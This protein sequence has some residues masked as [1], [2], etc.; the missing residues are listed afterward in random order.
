MAQ[1]TKASRAAPQRRFENYVLTRTTSPDIALA[2]IPDSAMTPVIAGNVTDATTSLLNIGFDFSF[3]NITYKR[4]I[5]NNN[6]WLALAGPTE[7]TSGSIV[8]SLLLSESYQNEGINLTNVS[9]NVLVC[10]WFDSLR[11]VTNTVNN[12]T[13]TIGA[14]KANRISQGI[15]TPPATFDQTNYGVR[16]FNDARSRD[17]RRLVV[18]WT[19]V[20]DYAVTQFNNIVKFD[21]VIYENGKIEFRYAPRSDISLTEAS[22]SIS[23]TYVQDATV[24]IF[25]PGTNRFRDFSPGLGHN[26]NRRRQHKYGGAEYDAS[27]ADAGLENVPTSHFVSRPYSWRL[28]TNVHW[29]SSEN[30]GGI[31]TFAPPMNKRRVL[32]R[33]ILRTVDAE[34]RLPTVVRTGGTKRKISSFFD[35]RKTVVYVDAGFNETTQVTTGVLVNFP[36]TLQRFHGGTAPGVVERQNLFVGDYEFTASISK[37]A[38]DDFVNQAQ[39][40]T[41][42][43]WSEHKLFAADQ[44]ATTD[45][46][47]SGSNIEQLGDG[48]SQPLRA[49]TQLRFSLPVNFT[50][51]M[52]GISSSIYYYNAK[53][54]CWEIPQNSV[55]HINELATTMPA[56]SKGD[57][58]RY[59]SVTGGAVESMRGFNAIGG[60][61]VSGSTAPLFGLP[62]TDTMINASYSAENVATALTRNYGKSINVNPNYQATQNE[63]LTLPINHDFLIEKAVIDIPLAFGAGWFNDV[64]TA[65]Q[66]L[67]NPFLEVS[68]AFD[69]GGPALTVSLFNQFKLGN[70][71][72]RELIMT[73]TITHVDDNVARIVVSNFPPITNT[74]Q[75]RQQG[76]KAFNV[77]P[78]AIVTPITT[79]G[80]TMTFTGSVPVKMTAMTSN[81][82]TVNVMRSMNVV[83]TQLNLSGV[84]ELFNTPK[85]QLGTFTTT[86]YDQQTRMPYINNF[87]RGATGFEQSGRSLFGKEFSTTSAFDSQ[88][89]IAN[90]FYLAEGS[91]GLTGENIASKLSSTRPQIAQAFNTGSRFISVAAIPLVSNTPSPYLVKKADTLVFAISKTKPV[92][93]STDSG[94]TSGSITH[95]VQ[96]LTGAINVTLYGSLIKEGREYHDTLD[97][98]L[99]SDAVHEVVIGNEPVLDQFEGEYE[100]MF[101]SGTFDDYVAGTI[102]RKATVNNKIVLITGSRG[103]VFSRVDARES[104]PVQGTTAFDSTTSVS[105]RSQPCYELAGNVRFSQHVDVSERYWDSMM[106]AIDKCFKANGA[107]I[108]L[109]SE[110][111]TFFNFPVD[112]SA[113]FIFFDG[114]TSDGDDFEEL[115]DVV[116]NN[117]TWSYPFEPR[118]AGISRHLAIEKT[119]VANKFITSNTALVNIPPKIIKGF[120]FGPCSSQYASV[121]PRSPSTILSGVVSGHDYGALNL[122]WIADSFIGKISTTTGLQLTSSAGVADVVKVLYGFGDLNTITYSTEAEDPNT[123]LGLRF[124]TNHFA[125]TRAKQFVSSSIWS[126]SPIIRGWKYGAVSGLPLFTKA[127]YRQGR[128]GQMRDML[129]QRPSTKFYQ[130]AENSPGTPGFKPGVTQAAV[131]VKFVDSDG[132]LTPPGNTWSNNLSFE[133]TSSMPY[134][135]DVARS[136]PEIDQNQLNTSIISFSSDD[137]I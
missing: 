24:G 123:N 9:R 18:R 136:R 48:L 88:G 71:T 124:G 51:T 47:F 125:D 49:K 17:G 15:E 119:F 37:Q 33:T 130:S 121:P 57:I 70:T 90:P 78:S 2:D 8:T 73:G 4:F 117:W 12:L 74:F 56:N 50:T 35:D 10:P 101:A 107:D 80:G 67:Q 108:F 46:F 87:G 26:D 96:L 89:K 103:R 97:Q 81:G 16:I 32:P 131:T 77:E 111:N 79:S 115:A 116:D 20:N 134:L 3:D 104:A 94:A 6:G 30:A 54:K 110:Q 105:V 92:F 34:N 65:M 86:N 11:T 27:Y 62:Q 66:H 135:D 60:A 39:A 69:I 91:G 102:V 133:A 99:S 55:T 31:F 95:D 129:E 45:P 14:Q 36:T 21:A 82:V 112:K 109:L 126:N 25:V 68:G 127:Y 7:V 41:I 118:Y 85:L 53:S 59:G 128:Y 1:T 132:N 42:G 113:G 93:Y 23:D 19:C 63:L 28:R 76:I 98:P 13:G 64:T 84:L 40:T 120:Y 106:P 44:A 5:V 75:I 58:A 22:S 100:N 83:N 52:F 137:T 122:M 38:S 43:P 72:Q 114:T 29:P 61:V